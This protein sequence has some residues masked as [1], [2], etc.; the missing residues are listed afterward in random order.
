[1]G[2]F[3]AIM[4]VVWVLQKAA[5]DAALDHE[6]AKRG[7]VSPRLAHKYGGADRARAKVAKYG[8]TDYL[9]DSYRD[10]WARRTD[11]TI[12][13]RDARPVDGGQRVTLRDRHRAAKARIVTDPAQTVGGVAAPPDATPPTRPVPPPTSPAPEPPAPTSPEPPPP[14]EAP[15]VPEPQ[16]GAT[17]ASDA[18]ADPPTPAP[19]AAEAVPDAAG[20]PTP[21]G[22]DVSAPTGEVL[23]YETA[24]AENEAMQQAVKAAIDAG[25]AALSSMSS[26]KSAVNDVQTVYNPTADAAVAKLDQLSA[27]GLDTTTITHAAAQVDALPVGAVDELYDATEQVESEIAA[28]VAQAQIAL[29]ALQAERAELDAN[30]AAASETVATNLGGDPTFVG[31]GAAAA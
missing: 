26:A 31:S 6:Y 28:R 10:A 12:A 23:N 4:I 7:E 30:Y 5:R 9:R 27:M 21:G 25:M 29:A 18:A 15:A 11:A 24:C 20:E 14:P 8:F 13:A 16:P 19:P 22:D 17:P 3:L 2:V 1:M